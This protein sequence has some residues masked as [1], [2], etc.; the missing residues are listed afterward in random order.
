M[1]GSIPKDFNRIVD[2]G[3]HAEAYVEGSLFWFPAS[4][5]PMRKA[6]RAF[7]LD[8]L[9]RLDMTLGGMFG[10]S[11]EVF[12]L[13]QTVAERCMDPFLNEALQTRPLL[14]LGRRP[15]ASIRTGVSESELKAIQESGGKV[16][17]FAYLDPHFY[18]L[19]GGDKAEHRRKYFGLGGMLLAYPKS[20]AP[21]PMQVPRMPDFM[22]KHP[23]IMDVQKKTPIETEVQM[24]AKLQSPF[25]E[26][27]RSK[28]LADLEPTLYTKSIPFVLPLLRSSDFFQQPPEYFADIFSMFHCL[29]FESP[30]DGGVLI[31]AETKIEAQVYEVRRA[32]REAGQ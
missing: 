8:L 31:A 26:Q 30:E 32:M 6:D 25:L 10:G 29:I 2:P 20:A 15:G 24:A 9:A 23:A 19:R 3:R 5:F 4:A 16:E 18:W 28:L 13:Q 27:S 21:K 7:L 14:G 1:E 22:M 11:A 12:L 17:P